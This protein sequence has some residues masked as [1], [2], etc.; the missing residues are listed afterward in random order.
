MVDQIEIFATQKKFV[1][2]VLKGKDSQTSFN[3]IIKTWKTRNKVEYLITSENIEIRLDTIESI[4]GI[5][6]N[7]SC[8][9]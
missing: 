5:S 8:N 1:T 7:N 9:I 2:I 3:T 4:D 6:F